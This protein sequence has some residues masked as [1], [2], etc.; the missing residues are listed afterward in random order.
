MNNLRHSLMLRC[1]VFVILALGLSSCVT[2]YQKGDV[3]SLPP[4]LMQDEVIR[5]YTTLGRI[6][7]STDM[8]LSQTPDPQE[9][10]KR[11]LREEAARMGADAVMLPE[12]S[13][14]PAPHLI[15][16]ANEYRATGV[17][18]RFK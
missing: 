5:P 6:K 9:W 18:I 7:L 15:I 4:I 8:Y 13:S 10:G 17:A 3:S 11:V 2:F 14:R 12:I 16:P 1:T